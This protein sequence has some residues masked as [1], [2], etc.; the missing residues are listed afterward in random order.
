LGKK[1]KNEKKLSEKGKMSGKMKLKEKRK[2]N[3]KGVKRQNSGRGVKI[4][5]LQKRKK[6][7][8]GRGQRYGFRIN[9]YR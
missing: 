8:F 4:G 5:T 9:I 1:G 7:L 2:N 6:Y 3:L